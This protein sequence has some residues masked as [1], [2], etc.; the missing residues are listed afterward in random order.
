MKMWQTFF[1]FLCYDSPINKDFIRNVYFFKFF[2]F[3][4]PAFLGTL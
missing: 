1:S 2:E 4:Y 3:L